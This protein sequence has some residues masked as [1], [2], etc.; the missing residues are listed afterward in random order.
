MN[1]TELGALEV[2]DTQLAKLAG[3]SARRI[4]QLAEQGTL[5]KVRLGRYLLGPAFSA[6]IE[7]ASGKGS[8][9][10]KQRT[11]KVRADADLAELNLAREL[12]QV[13]PI[14]EMQKVWDHQCVLIRTNMLN[15]PRRVISSIVGESDERKIKAI[16]TDEIK[17]VLRD[18]AEQHPP[19]N[20]EYE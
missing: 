7:E 10:Q 14:A 5:Q 11:R 6:L 16:L 2:T 17:Q 20:E 12:E 1:D 18:S 4:R 19:E 3:V 9:L 13:A 8:E 15:I